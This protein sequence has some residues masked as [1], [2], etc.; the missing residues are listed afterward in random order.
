MYIP[1]IVFIII[2]VICWSYFDEMEEKIDELNEKLDEKD[3]YYP[4]DYD[5]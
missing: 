3:N 1:V 4:D 5:Y 2:V